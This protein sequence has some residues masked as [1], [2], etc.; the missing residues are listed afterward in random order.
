MAYRSRTSA[1]WTSAHAFF[2]ARRCSDGAGRLG[3]DMG[4]SAFRAAG[5]AAA[6]RE[7]GYAVEDRGNIAP[8]PSRPATHGNPAIKSLPEIVAWTEAVAEATYQ[9]IASGM[10]IVCGGDHS[11][12]AGTLLGVSRRAAERGRELFVLWLDAHPDFHTLDSTESGNLHGV[13]LAYAAGR[14]GFAGTFPAFAHPIHAENICTLGIRSVDLAERS[15]LTEAGV[16]MYDMR[17]IDEHGIAALLQRFLARVAAA[18]GVLHVSLDVDFL[19][20]AIAPGVGTTVPGG[21]TFREAHLVMETAARQ[22]ARREP[23]PGGAQPVPRRTRPDRHPDGGSRLEPDGPPRARPANAKLSEPHPSGT[24]P[25]GFKDPAARLWQR[26]PEIAADLRHHHLHR[27]V[28]PAVEF[29]P[30]PT[31][32]PD[33]RTAARPPRHTLWRVITSPTLRAICRRAMARRSSGPPCRGQ[34]HSIRCISAA[35]RRTAR[36]TRSNACAA[37]R[38]PR[39]RLRQRRFAH[40][41]REPG[42]VR[43]AQR[44]GAI[45]P[46][47]QTRRD[48][49]D[50][51]PFGL[52]RLPQPPVRSARPDATNSIS[53]SRKAGSSVDVGGREGSDEIMRH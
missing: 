18:D 25:T 28:Q 6:L 9:A 50:D 45:H 52:R 49:R 51:A 43:L 13:P 30:D 46:R 38:D 1:R 36:D 5:L 15:A 29:Q 24:S 10:P 19:D 40:V 32:R 12:T 4:P 3:C 41:H 2:S 8:A 21:A 14:P 23:R 27:L 20:P 22:R 53:A 31:A 26:Q 42:L 44:P 11:L 7:L 35:V 34:P 37:A 16:V 47:G 17:A 39:R 48:D 33:R